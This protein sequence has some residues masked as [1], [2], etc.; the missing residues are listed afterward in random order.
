MKTLAQ[1]ALS[2]GASAALLVGCGGSQPPI[3]APAFVAPSN[4]HGQK[5]SVQ[6]AGRLTSTVHYVYV[7]NGT[8]DNVSAFA[9]DTSSGALTQVEGSPFGAG[10]RPV[11]EAID[12]VGAFIYVANGDS[13]NVSAYVINT[14]SG[15][16][17][18][19]Q[20]QPFA[21]G[22]YPWQVA[23]DP[24]GKFAY[25][26]NAGVSSSGNVSAYTINA[27]SGAL[28]QVK[29]SPF[30]AGT[31][32]SGVAIDP[33]GKFAYVPNSGDNDVSAYT[34]NASS[35][36]LTQLKG[37]PF[38]AGY[39]PRKVAINGTFVYV[40]NFDSN[41]VSAYAIN[42][43]SG[44][45]TQVPGSPF[46]AGTNPI[47]VAIDPTGAFLYV[48]NH[49][50]NN[51]SAYAVNPSSGALTQVQG[52]PFAAGRP[53]PTAVAIDSTGEFAYVADIGCCRGRVSAFAINASSGALTKVKG[54]PFK[55]GSNP[56]DV[57]VR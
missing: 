30:A 47:G 21:A 14:E 43:K 41:N 56:F 45:L 28:T 42:A 38:A 16:L 32:P 22:S 2:I 19:V 12:P 37:S 39:Q 8:S 24:T 20:G 35:G 36:A 31:S 51:I 50:S 26:A 3:G 15:A 53:L 11:G 17:T 33:T 57:V 34:I 18:Q 54:S 13:D 48:T 52:S 44:A 55:A 25:V 27:S 1:Y 49:G 40:T 23:I 9:I 6:S 10:S 46:E 5:S 7:T 29:G 4:N